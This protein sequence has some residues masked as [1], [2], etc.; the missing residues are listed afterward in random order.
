MKQA[1]GA[2]GIYDP[3][4]FLL[5]DISFEPQGGDAGRAGRFCERR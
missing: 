2:R 1:E 5:V 4:V 3:A